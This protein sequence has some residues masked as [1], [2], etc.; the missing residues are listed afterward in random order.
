MAVLIPAPGVAA[1]RAARG[2]PSSRRIL[3]AVLLF[4]LLGVVVRPSPAAE[5]AGAEYAI[6]ANYLYKLGPFV[7]W[8]ARSFPTPASPFNVCVLGEDPFGSALDEAVRG[9]TVN[10]HPVEVRRLKAAPTDARC[11]V[12]YLGRFRSEPAA[13]VLRSLQGQPVLTVTDA[14]QGMVGGMVHFVLKDGRVRFALDVAAAQASGLQLS[15]K[16]QSLAVS[17]QRA[18]G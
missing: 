8:P 17:L 6:K 15:S 18:G 12:L 10:G 2:R 4:G 16:L 9:Q 11:Q 1:A 3:L 5:L 14:G 7:D 13:E